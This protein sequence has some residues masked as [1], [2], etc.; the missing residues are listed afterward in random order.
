[1]ITAAGG[2]IAG[3]LI[4]QN[5][6]DIPKPNV[7]GSFATAAV[8]NAGGAAGG[9]VG[10]SVAGGWVM[11]SYATGPVTGIN[12]AAAGGLVGVL[13][14][15]AGATQTSYS[16]G[17]VSSGSGA[18]VGGSIGQDLASGGIT[19][20]YWDL[21]TSGVS[22]PHQG[23]GNVP[24]DPGITGLTDAQLKSGLPPGFDK[25]VWAINPKI[26]NGYPYLINN[27]PPK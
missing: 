6:H 17:A 19:N 20:D 18:S 4:G 1:M 8:S 27:P 12:T 3:G 13:S 15:D 25:K 23:A 24:D 7:S 5:R 21:D 22:N 9:L 10:Q 26:N 2:A 14:E 16:T 11:D